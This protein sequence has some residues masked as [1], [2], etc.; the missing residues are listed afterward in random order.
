MCH[1]LRLLSTSSA[2]AF[3][4]T[5]RI[6]VFTRNKTLNVLITADAQATIDGNNFA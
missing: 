3:V 6:L 1:V 4:S 5:Q 2:R